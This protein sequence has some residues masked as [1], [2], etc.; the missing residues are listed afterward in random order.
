MAAEIAWDLYRTFLGVLREGSLSGAA[1][2]LGITQPTAG[3]H[4]AMLERH[5]GVPLFTRSPKGFEPTQAAMALRTHA[6][7]MESTAAAL[8]RAASGQADSVRT[9]TKHPVLGTVRVSVSEVLGIEVLPPMIRHLRSHHPGVHV[10]LAI[11]NAVQDLLRLEADIAIRTVQPLQERLVARS[12]GRIEFGLFA[13]EDYLRQWGTPQTLED[14]AGHSLIGFD[15]PPAYVDQVL[16][17]FKGIS[18]D[19]FNVRTDSDLAQ[20]ALIRAGAGIGACQVGLA[21]PDPTLTRVLPKAFAW[22]RPIWIAMHE[23]LRKVPRCR[24]TFDALV[25]GIQRYTASTS[26]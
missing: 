5:L 13:H 11:T 9:G 21:L 15:H 8:V 20:L 12:L 23:D 17:S 3:R 10:E 6:Q 18:R 4:V 24:V 26:G 16:K 22:K 7:A 25:S 19:R 1:R 14:I 2:A